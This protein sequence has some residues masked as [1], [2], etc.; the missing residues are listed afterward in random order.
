MDKILPSY[1]TDMEKKVRNALD[2]K[3]QGRD[4]TYYLQ[5]WFEEYDNFGNGNF[6]LCYIDNNRETLDLDATIHSMDGELL[7]KVAIDLGVE[8]PHY[9][10][11]IPIFR[12]ELKT[13]YEFA[14]R[15]F[16]K[17]FREVESDPDTACGLAVAAL[18]SIIK[19]IL[20][21][22]RI[23]I[24]SRDKGD[25]HKLM[26][27]ILRAYSILPNGL[28]FSEIRT[29]VSGLQKCATALGDIRGDKS[30]LHGHKTGDIIISDAASAYFVV[31]AITTIGLYLIQVYKKQYPSVIYYNELSSE[32]LPF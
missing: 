9:I 1:K 29:L 17:A 8:T 5:N 22:N 19:E 4:A 32:D 18:E 30:S 6:C 14:S 2:N 20:L 3:Y 21:D 26:D 27:D 11:S 12:N 31:N 23:S 7:L 13:S 24:K 16:E 28:I 10:P 15:T 25:I